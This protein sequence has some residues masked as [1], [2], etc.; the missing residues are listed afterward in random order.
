MPPFSI[1]D[2]RAF[3]DDTSFRATCSPTDVNS[4][5]SSRNTGSTVFSTIITMSYPELV[6]AEPDMNRDRLPTFK[7]VLQRRTLSPVDLFSFYIYMRDQMFLVDY[8]DF[9]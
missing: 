6:P 8:L 7:E 2:N 5:S 9:W 3:Y 1:R 4:T